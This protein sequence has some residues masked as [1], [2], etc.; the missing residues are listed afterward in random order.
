[1]K[2]TKLL[3]AILVMQILLFCGQWFGNTP[4]RASQG[5]PDAGAQRA[6]I[7]DQLRSV[8][9]KLDKLTSVMTDGSLQVHVV[10]SDDNARK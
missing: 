2:T 10:K 6:D 8:N 1:M 7:L 9:D 4:A 3:T 5:I